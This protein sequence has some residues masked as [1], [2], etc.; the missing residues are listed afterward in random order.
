MRNPFKPTFGATP[1]LLAGRDDLIDEFADALAEGPGA[2]A[3]ASLYTGA[4][5]AGKTVMLNAVQ[6]AAQAGGWLV[7]SE[8]A[9]R[10]LIE[11]LTQSRL[12][13]LLREFDPD[14]STTSDQYQ[15][16]PSTSPLARAALARMSVAP[17]VSHSTSNAGRPWTSDAGRMK[18]FG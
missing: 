12:R 7:V 9:T 8:T 6:D 5:G 17:N 1:P 15:K 10:G 13:E 16:L 18:K 3:R 11:R 4:R 2:S 14:E